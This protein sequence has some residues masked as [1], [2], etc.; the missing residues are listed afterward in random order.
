MFLVDVFFSH[1]MGHLILNFIYLLT[2]AFKTYQLVL[3]LNYTV[4]SVHVL[5]DTTVE[6]LRE[7]KLRVWG[8]K[9][10]RNNTLP[11]EASVNTNFTLCA[12][13]TA[14]MMSGCRV[15]L[16]P[17]YVEGDHVFLLSLPKK[18]FIT[19]GLGNFLSV[20]LYFFHVFI[21]LRGI[22][23]EYLNPLRLIVCLKVLKS[24]K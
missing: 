1:Q 3:H 9:A 11:S 8:E 10:C 23:G 6:Y 24:K 14:G 7:V 22:M 12:G 18:K 17:L 16:V 15:S 21:Y 13:Y 19:F 2:T 5:T 20:L 4:N